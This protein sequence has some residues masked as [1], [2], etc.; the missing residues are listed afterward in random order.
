MEANPR[1][2]AARRRW[3]RRNGGWGF[4]VLPK[5]CGTNKPS[6]LP[7]FL[8]V[9]P[10]KQCGTNPPSSPGSSPFASP[11]TSLSVPDGR[12]FQSFQ[13]NV[14][15]LLP[16]ATDASNP[17]DGASNPTDGTTLHEL[18][19][20]GSRGRPLSSASYSDPGCSSGGKRRMHVIRTL[21]RAGEGGGLPEAAREEGGPEAA[22]GGTGTAGASSSITEFFPKLQCAF[23]TKTRSEETS[24]LTEYIRT[25][26]W[27]VVA[28]LLFA[29]VFTFFS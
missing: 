15:P 8:A 9:R 16:S 5:Q 26:L 7:R 19:R 10:K 11:K 3:G 17:A 23:V 25:Q 1:A 6:Q 28:F 4:P 20:R 24:P 27:L 29:Q 22:R 18:L 21:A 12:N 2:A 14:E 13:N